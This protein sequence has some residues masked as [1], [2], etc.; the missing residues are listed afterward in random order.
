M[1]GLGT[2]IRHLL[3]VVVEQG[4]HADR[5]RARTRRRGGARGVRTGP[6]PELTSKVSPEHVVPGT[7]AGKGA[8][9]RAAPR[10]GPAPRGGRAGLTP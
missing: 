3:P 9:R 4:D 7:S 8:Q 10:P 1:T 2:V 5:G 6:S